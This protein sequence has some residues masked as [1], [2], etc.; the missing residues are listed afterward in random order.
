MKTGFTFKGKH[1]KDMGVSVATK[2]RPILPSIRRLTFEPSSGDGVIDLSSH[3]ELGRPLYNERIFS[4]TMLVIAP[5][6]VSLQN[7][8]ASVVSWLAGS[9]E[10]VFDDI[11]GVVWDVSRTEQIDYAPELQG[12]KALLSVAFHAS[13]FS[14][15]PFTAAEG[16]AIGMDIPIGAKIPIGISQTVSITA[17]S[18]SGTMVIH[19]VGT[20]SVRPVITVNITGEGSAASMSVS[21]GSKKVSVYCALDSSEI[22]MDLEHGKFMN[23]GKQTALTE[24]SLFELEPGKNEISYA[25]VPKGSTITVSYTPKFLYSWEV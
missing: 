15:A 6:I 3:N 11:P 9:G 16:P 8:L 4:V 19:N 17:E 22:I 7:K 25:L 20:A 5:N 18:R 2:S 14:R 24:F 21:K 12:R 10:L 13:A 23:N 1:T